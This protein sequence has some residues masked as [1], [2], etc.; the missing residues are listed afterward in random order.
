MSYNTIMI[1]ADTFGMLGV[2]CSYFLRKDSRLP[3]FSQ[4]IAEAV[5]TGAT[6]TAPFERHPRCRQEAVTLTTSVEPSA[7]S[8]AT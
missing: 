2:P 6:R 4:K 7:A 1:A 5:P 3:R 8:S